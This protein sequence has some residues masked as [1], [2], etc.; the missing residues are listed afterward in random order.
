MTASNIRSV[1]VPIRRAG[2]F[3]LVELL[4]VIGIIALLVSILLPTLSKAREAANKAKC[5]SN[6][7]Q[8]GQSNS[9]YIAQWKGWAVPGILGN[10]NDTFPGT[11]TKVRA[12]WLNNNAFRK[13]LNMPEWIAG[14][15]QQ[16]HAP[17]GLVCPTATQANEKGNNKGML[18]NNSYGY[19]I[20]HL[21]YVPKP[22]I[23]T[24]PTASQ[25]N[26]ATEFAGI[27]ANRVRTPSDKIQFMDAMTPFVQPQV[28]N[29]YYKIQGFE[30]WKDDATSDGQTEDT[31]TAYRHAKDKKSNSAQV[32]IVFWDGHAETMQRGDVVAVK[33]PQQPA[34]ADGPVANRTEA[35]TH[36]WELG[37]R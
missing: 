29:H 6:L 30:D 2:G 14:N 9:L 22:L 25:W 10:N 4:V 7:R 28:S 17:A 37:V 19:N 15:G 24:L 13:N 34:N 3:T 5:L 26:A 31:Y 32:N 18:L 35:W 1:R 33:T 23:I 27:K 20:R 8:L 11:S 21:N 16:N 36:R 12:T